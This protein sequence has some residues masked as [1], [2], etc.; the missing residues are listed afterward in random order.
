MG[1]DIHLCIDYDVKGYKKDTIRTEHFA[2]LYGERDYLLFGLFTNGYVRIPEA[3]G[4]A[5]DP[6]GIP[7]RLSWKTLD[8]YSY[9]IIKDSDKEPWEGAV[10]ESSARRYIQGD[11]ISSR[12][13]QSD[14]NG[15]LEYFDGDPDSIDLA[16]ER[17]RV[18]G[19]D[20]H[21]PSWLTADELRNVLVNYSKV[22]EQ[23]WDNGYYPISAEV[24]GWYGALR[25]LEDDKDVLQA[26]LVFWF[27]N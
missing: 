9:C 18:T 3:D 5:P 16:K 21:T 25:A 4:F 7:E 12:L 6:K 22:G 24:I 23:L 17:W 10:F 2:K 15:K 11:Y 27:D 19:P 8:E 20:W 14:G 1:C 26:R 13:V